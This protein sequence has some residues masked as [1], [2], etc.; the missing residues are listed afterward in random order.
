M[1]KPLQSDA[2]AVQMAAV[3]DKS[4]SRARAEAG[5]GA[6]AAQTRPGQTRIEA[7]LK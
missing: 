6:G 5:A 4:T 2:E 3:H 1:E 7:E